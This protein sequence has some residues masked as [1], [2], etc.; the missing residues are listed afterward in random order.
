M[1][2]RRRLANNYI[3]KELSVDTDCIRVSIAHKDCPD[4]DLAYLI[5]SIE[6]DIV[7]LE[8]CFTIL[9][10][11]NYYYDDWP[12]QLAFR[13]FLSCGTFSSSRGDRVKVIRKPLGF[14][15]S[16]GFEPDAEGTLV[17]LPP[18]SPPR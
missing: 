5:I 16:L 13:G 8:K 6:E 9:E 1:A 14:W 4:L 11:C 7:T 2:L 17:W 15:E 12:L 10:W 18:K 3:T